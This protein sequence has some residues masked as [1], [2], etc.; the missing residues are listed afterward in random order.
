MR[1]WECHFSR[2]INKYVWQL[3]ACLCSPFLPSRTVTYD[4]S[5]ITSA[6]SIRAFYLS[7]WTIVPE[8]FVASHRCPCHCCSSWV[9]GALVSELNLLF[10]SII[11]VVLL[12]VLT[13]S[14]VPP[15]M[16]M[17]YVS[18][19]TCHSGKSCFK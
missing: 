15:L 2:G 6:G 9:G 11:V 5:D 16:W 1:V 14:P 17:F 3:V 18:G 19:D 13:S 10:N 7:F 4:E 12:L 8:T